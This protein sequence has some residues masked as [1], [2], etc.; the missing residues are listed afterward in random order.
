MEY[1]SVV[2][3]PTT[4]FDTKTLEQVLRKATKWGR[5]KHCSYESRL[6][7]LNLHSLSA[8]RYRQDCVQLFKHFSGIQ[9]TSWVNPPHLPRRLTRGHCFKYVPESANDH[10]F[11]PRYDFLPNRAC[12]HW[13]SLP[14]AAVKASSVSSF[15]HEYDVYMSSP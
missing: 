13:N 8:R 5:L 2:W 15:K 7:S 4:V 6:R 12:N 1:A 10:S 14:E 11:S 9:K 3:P